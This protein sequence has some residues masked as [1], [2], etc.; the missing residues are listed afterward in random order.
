MNVEAKTS[1]YQYVHQPMISFQTE[2]QHLYSLAM[3]KLKHPQLAQSHGPNP[4]HIYLYNEKHSAVVH[5][6]IL[7]SVRCL[8]LQWRLPRGNRGPKRKTRL[9]GGRRDRGSAQSSEMAVA[10][11]KEHSNRAIILRLNLP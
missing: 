4:Y 8:S 7:H 5:V 1:N 3:S 6:Q 10:P 2:K 9:I 11:F